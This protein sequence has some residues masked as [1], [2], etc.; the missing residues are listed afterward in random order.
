LQYFFNIESTFCNVDA[1]FT[2]L[3]FHVSEMLIQHLRAVWD[4][5][6]T[7]TFSRKSYIIKMHNI[8][9]KYIYIL[10]KTKFKFYVH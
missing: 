3:Q 4:V 6:I 1:T 5:L 8:Y 9:E 2:M 7:K 10:D